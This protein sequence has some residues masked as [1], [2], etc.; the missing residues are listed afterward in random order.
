MSFLKN[1]IIRPNSGNLCGW[2]TGSITEDGKERLFSLE[3]GKVVLW[4]AGKKDIVLQPTEIKSFDCVAENLKRERSKGSN[5]IMQCDQYTI[6][7]NNGISGVMTIF[8]GKIGEVK[9]ALNRL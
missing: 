8:K 4:M 9:I 1:F 7:L 3:N 2:V 6:V 5:Q